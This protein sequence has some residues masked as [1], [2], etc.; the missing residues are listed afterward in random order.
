MVT[1]PFFKKTRPVSYSYT[2]YTFPFFSF[3]FNYKDETALKQV[4]QNQRSSTVQVK[5]KISLM[6]LIL[7][8]RPFFTLLACLHCFANI[9]KGQAFRYAPYL[10]PATLNGS[11]LEG[12]KSNR[13][14]LLQVERCIATP[15]LK[16]VRKLTCFQPRCK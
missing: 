5:L 1:Y 12:K 2:I 6:L 14:V 8:P 10:R 13:P 16:A 9:L 3:P 7:L 15:Q 4:E 11:A